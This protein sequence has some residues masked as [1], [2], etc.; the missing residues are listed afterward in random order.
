MKPSPQ[1]EKYS[2]SPPTASNTG[3]SVGRLRETSEQPDAC[4]MP[5]GSR[6]PIRQNSDSS[7]VLA[8][9]QD[10]C[11]RSNCKTSQMCQFCPKEFKNVSQLLLHERDHTGDRP[12]KCDVCEK[13][14]SLSRN[15]CAHKR[16]HPGRKQHKCKTC[17]TS[18]LRSTALRRHERIHSGERPFTC[19]TCVRFLHSHPNY[20]TMSAYIQENVHIGAES[21]Q[22]SS[23]DHHVFVDTS[24][25]ITYNEEA[26]IHKKGVFRC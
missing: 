3:V 20:M 14:F 2:L 11:K 24:V 4:D 13:S 9:K 21:A 15:L 17:G 7:K 18:F 5:V 22:S 1:I 26:K 25:S 12:F 10:L 6:R 16:T 19:K 23:D 8:Q